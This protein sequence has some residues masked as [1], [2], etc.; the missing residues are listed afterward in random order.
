[1]SNS[2]REF[3]DQS[4][5]KPAQKVTAPR[6]PGIPKDSSNTLAGSTSKGAL[7]NDEPGEQ[8]RPGYSKAGMGKQITLHT[9]YFDLVPQADL[10]IHRYTV[11]ILQQL[12]PAIAEKPDPAI[13]DR[14]DSAKKD[15]SDP[16][17][18]QKLSDLEPEKHV[19]E[20]SEAGK[21]P[22]LPKDQKAQMR[23]RRRLFEI[24]L[25]DKAFKEAGLHVATDYASILLSSKELHL[26]KDT[27]DV[28][29]RDEGQEK[30]DLGIWATRLA[31]K[32]EISLNVQK[33]VEYLR[34][35]SKT[36]S[37][38]FKEGC[39]QALNI[40]VKQTA[41]SNPG[42]F[43]SA[44]NS[45]FYPII[46][47]SVELAKCLV[48][49]KG[50]QTSVRTSISRLLV[51][52]HACTSAF[53]QEAPVNKIMEVLGQVP[54]E[55]FLKKCRIRTKYTGSY[56]YR[57]IRGY[58]RDPKTKEIC[59]AAGFEIERSDKGHEGEKISIA[60]YF[61]SKYDINLEG[62]NYPLL[63]LGV[64]KLRDTDA[65][66]ELGAQKRNLS[67][68]ADRTQSDK[69]HD[70]HGPNNQIQED[71]DHTTP[72]TKRPPTKDRIIM[73]PPELCYLVPGQSFL[74][75]LGD[76]E[77]EKMKKFAA[78]PPGENARRIEYAAKDILELSG[79]NLCLRHFGLDISPRLVCVQGRRLDH[80]S[81]EYRSKTSKSPGRDVRVVQQPKEGSWNL[82]DAHLVT[83]KSD[84]CFSVLRIFQSRCSEEAY[85]V[86]ATHI[87]AFK[88]NFI[89]CGFASV[90][91]NGPE[92]GYRIDIPDSS[93]LAGI[94]DRL[95]KGLKVAQEPRIDFVLVLLPKKDTYLYGRIKFLADTKL[96]LHTVCTV[97]DKFIKGKRLKEGGK[98]LM[99]PMYVANVAMKV[100][101][102]LDGQNHAL[103]AKNLT[104]L[105][106]ATTM[107]VGID[108]NHPSHTVLQNPQSIAGVV[109]NT[110]PSNLSQWPCSLRT[111]AG[112]TE[113][114]EDLEEMISEHLDNWV[115]ANKDYPKRLLVYRDG[116]SESQY[117]QIRNIELPKIRQACRS[118]GRSPQITIIVAA[119]RYGWFAILMV[120]PY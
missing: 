48:A 107:I 38:V 55:D 66:S 80:P 32:K 104:P 114:V 34:K 44:Q 58:A 69:G 91:L 56:K 111:Q 36:Q 84:V 90:Q 87:E 23:K 106:T 9:N 92:A 42:V 5:P 24:L 63:D 43:A 28:I 112:G 3:E 118:K 103:P 95:F 13:V 75:K 83:T 72:S 7:S 99:D 115:N 51:N 120:L 22:D 17:Q 2:V 61:K 50:Y 102:K 1:M 16:K 26:E 39:L 117:A 108:V 71:Q 10:L 68:S 109:A 96:G 14:P 35:P 119:K 52:V 30:P 40:I 25:E 12:N 18:K 11:T 79:D 54:A 86:K 29:Y 82:I 31:L 65:T 49:L 88:K 37:D 33:L 19:A 73:V 105:S 100:N 98:Q 46:G 81:I 89:A 57:T 77:T 110:G 113:M 4:V 47:E 101:L 70:A 15:Q 85:G 8:L 93:D 64:I 78:R 59:T 20:F 6:R 67:Q 21:L 45:K 116:V 76:D 74:T 97:P 41:N 27:I 62:R 94:D 60:G 53:Y